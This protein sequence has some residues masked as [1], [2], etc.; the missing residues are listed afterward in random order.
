MKFSAGVGNPPFQNPNEDTG[1]NLWPLFVEKSLDILKPGGHLALITPCTWMRP[2]ADIVRKGG[3][4]YVFNDFMKG[5][6]TKVINASN[7]K[8]HFQGVGST[9]SYYVICNEPPTGTTKIICDDG[10]IDMDLNGLS[11]FPY[12]AGIKSLSIFKKVQS[13]EL[14]FTF[15]NS[16]PKIEHDDATFKLVPDAVNQYMYVGG[17]YNA[18]KCNQTHDAMIYYHDKIHPAHNKPKIVINYVGA[19]K[20]Y[21]DDGNCGA[22]RC[23]VQLLINTDEVEPAKSVVKSKL[24]KFIYQYMRW[25]MHNEATAVNMLT[26]PPFTKV[27]TD[28]ELYAYYGLT[29]DEIA[30]VEANQP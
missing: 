11:V 2:T 29:Q 10:E 14:N 5:N 18:A 27:W 3:N 19:I 8:S 17:S 12:N 28:A 23:I 1:S 22:Q 7:L 6:N 15:K 24:F 21:V 9:F 26:R 13:K 25:G 30:Y 4:K 16:S 20:P